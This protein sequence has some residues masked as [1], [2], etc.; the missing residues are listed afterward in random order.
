MKD[1]KKEEKRG[2]KKGRWQ[3]GWSSD[4]QIYLSVESVA[5]AAVVVMTGDWA[6]V[7]DTVATTAGGMVLEV[8]TGGRDYQEKRKK[9]LHL[10]SEIKYA[11]HYKYNVNPG[12]LI[13]VF[14]SKWK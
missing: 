8:V 7:A 12:P 11:K 2:D 14:I 3:D 6:L 1:W 13:S 10:K 9:I 4:P 5:W